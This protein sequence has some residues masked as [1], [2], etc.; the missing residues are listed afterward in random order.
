MYDHAKTVAPQSSL[1]RFK[2]VRLLIRMHQDEVSQEFYLLS[3]GADRF[4][5][6]AEADL[7]ALQHQAANEPNVLYLLGQL[8]R[9]LGRRPEM[10]RFF[11][12][13]QD[14]EPRMAG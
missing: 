10:L 12:Q 6:A 3:C 9:N 14:L 11:A 5:Q 1:V 4:S 2:R 7:L 13:A 8:Y